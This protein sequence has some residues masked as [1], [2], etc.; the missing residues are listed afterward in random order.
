MGKPRMPKP[1]PT[2]VDPALNRVLNELLVEKVQV[3]PDFYDFVARWLEAPAEESDREHPWDPTRP[4][5]ERKFIMLSEIQPQANEALRTLLRY[6]EEN[7][8]P[9][10]EILSAWAMHR[11][12]WGD[13]APKRGRPPD[14][15]EAVAILKSYWLLRD[16]KRSHEEAIT[17][18]ATKLNAPHETI[19]STVRKYGKTHPIPVEIR[20]IFSP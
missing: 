11:G 7:G 5:L 20:P 19:R 10:S 18:I 3:G 6:L 17:I 13:P 8:E 14:V 12:V 16:L 4:E 2:V 9:A 1:K 15:N